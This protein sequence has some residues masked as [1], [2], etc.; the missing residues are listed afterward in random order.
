[1][2]TVK[3]HHLE[4]TWLAVASCSSMTMSPN[5]I[6]KW[7][8]TR[9]FYTVLC[10][11]TLSHRGT[12]KYSKGNLRLHFSFPQRCLH[13][14]CRI[15][16]CYSHLNTMHACMHTMLMWQLY[17]P[18]ISDIQLNRSTWKS[19][20][21]NFNLISILFLPYLTSVQEKKRK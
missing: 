12:N 6:K 18:L 21:C 14:C 20:E 15:T 9:D 1:M 11:E 10:N 7:E 16:K 13:V 8:V 2:N 3:Y 4:S 5:K 17:W 19:G